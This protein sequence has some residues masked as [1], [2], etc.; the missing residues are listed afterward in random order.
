MFAK[1]I[2][3]LIMFF[4]SVPCLKCWFCVSST[5]VVRLFLPLGIFTRCDF[6]IFSHRSV[7]VV[8]KVPLSAQFLSLILM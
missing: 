5:H 7:V 1:S 6:L 4:E 3:E 8:L 2:D